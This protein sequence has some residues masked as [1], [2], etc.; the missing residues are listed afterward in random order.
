MGMWFPFG[1]VRM[2]QNYIVVM[3]TQHCECTKCHHIVQFKMVKTWC[4][5]YICVCVF[6]HNCFK[7]K[8]RMRDKERKKEKKKE[9]KERKKERKSGQIDQY[10]NSGLSPKLQHV[11]GKN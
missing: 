6:S 11:I 8:E 9:R 7:C 2:F 4:V 10:R 1:G 3:V 5:L